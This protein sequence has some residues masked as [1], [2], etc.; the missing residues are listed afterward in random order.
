GG[1]K[2]EMRQALSQS[3]PV[4]DG[5]HDVK[6]RVILGNR[7]IMHHAVVRN[8]EPELADQFARRGDLIERAVVRAQSRR[9]IA[10]G[11]HVAGAGIDLWVGRKGLPDHLAFKSRVASVSIVAAFITSAGESSFSA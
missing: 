11:D 2:A 9:C 7:K 3:L 6:Y 10:E 5:R 4:A 1:V 8:L